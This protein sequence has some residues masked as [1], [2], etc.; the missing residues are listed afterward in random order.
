VES[1]KKVKKDGEDDGEVEDG[2]EDDKSAGDVK[3]E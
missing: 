2:S 3:E 1:G